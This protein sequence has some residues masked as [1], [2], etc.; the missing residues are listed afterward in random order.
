MP[1]RTVILHSRDCPPVGGESNRT[2]SE[3][4][5]CCSAVSIGARIYYSRRKTSR[6]V[7]PRRLPREMS[8]TCRYH[9]AGS[10][11]RGA[12]CPFS[13]DVDDRL[14]GQGSSGIVADTK[15]VCKFFLR[16]GE[17]HCS[18]GDRCKYL[19]VRPEFDAVSSHYQAPVGVPTP[20]VDL[21]A[22]PFETNT[23]TSA[24]DESSAEEVSVCTAYYSTGTC[25]NNRC[26]LRHDFTQ[27]SLCENWTLH[28]DDADAA[29][30]HVEECTARHK[31][32][33]MR[34]RS[35][36][37]ECGIC[38]EPVIE[39]NRK[40]GLLSCDHAFCLRCIRNWRSN[41]SGGADVDSALRTCPICRTTSWFI[42]PSA[43][44]PASAEDRE[45]IVAG[46]KAKLASIDC[47]LFN[48]GDGACPFAQSCFYKHA[49]R[50]GTL[51]DSRPRTV[52]VDEDE[53]KVVQPVKLC[54]WIGDK[55]AQ[56]ERRRR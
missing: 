10:C 49:Y 21:P 7:Q 54:D 41:T 14:A 12:T 22:D 5:D 28:P 46:Y 37:I 3:R 38:L 34:A 47:R 27:C 16:G 15:K 48:F 43:V 24:L 30:R 2:S 53:V 23:L 20:D 4:S 26:P 36:H 1:R 51:E 32:I 29:R 33:E 44:W 31:R 11:T 42:V 8:P 13:H 52:A 17:Y 9:L 40:F 18:F 45:L 19:H 39:N 55:L 56:H 25:A 35:Q 50:D 6:G